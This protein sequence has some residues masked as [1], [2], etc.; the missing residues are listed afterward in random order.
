MTERL[1]L[2]KIHPENLNPFRNFKIYLLIFYDFYSFY[3]IYLFIFKHV[4]YLF[5][6]FMVSKQKKMDFG[7]WF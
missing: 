7:Q 4:Q 3:F 2:S 5:K 1:S 6:T